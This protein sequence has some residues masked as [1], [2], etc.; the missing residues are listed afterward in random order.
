MITGD[1]K[2]PGKDRYSGKPVNGGAR[3]IELVLGT[4]LRVLGPRAKVACTPGFVA[5]GERR[6]MVEAVGPG[7]MDDRSDGSLRI[8]I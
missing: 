2:T 7:V 5:D 3:T 1:R 4:C 8:Q 6:F